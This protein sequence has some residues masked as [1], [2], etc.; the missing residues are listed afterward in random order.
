MGGSCFQRADVT[1]DWR[2]ARDVDKHKKETTAVSRPRR[3]GGG[4]RECLPFEES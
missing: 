2:K 1:E 4:A 3:E